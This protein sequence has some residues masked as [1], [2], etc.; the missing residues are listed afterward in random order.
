LF[1]EV[2]PCLVLTHGRDDINRTSLLS[3]IDCD[4]RLDIDVVHNPSTAEDGSFIDFARKCVAAGTIRSFTLFEENI[5]N[6][7]FLL[8]LL[9]NKNRYDADFVIVSDG[10][11]LAPKTLVD[12]Q[13]AI[14]EHHT[15]VLACGLRLDATVWDDSLVIKDDF[16]RRFNTSRYDEGDYLN[17]AT[18]MWMTM[19]RGPEL[20]SIL[21]AIHDNGLRLTDANLKQ[22]GAALFQKQ[23]VATKSSVGRELN[24]ERPDYHGTKAI[25][26]QHFAHHSPEPAGSKYATW[27]H[28]CVAPAVEWDRDGERPVNFAP[29][30]EARPRFR[31]TIENDPVVSKLKSGQLHHSR[32]YLANHLLAATNPGLAFIISDGHCSTGLPHLGPERSALYIST[33]PEPGG[34]LAALEEVDLGPVLLTLEAGHCRSILST[35]ARFLGKGAL[36]HGILFGADDVRHNSSLGN[37]PQASLL[38]PALRGSASELAGKRGTGDGAI[39]EFVQ[40]LWTDEA[41]QD[42]LP[43]GASPPF[44]SKSVKNPNLSYFRVTL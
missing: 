26:T 29:L 14:F 34:L 9:G 4:P 39:G 35:T 22:L 43:Q 21:E 44:F 3:I 16:V 40:Q 41:L 42:W 25:S 28:N 6:N 23:W 30:P 12:E 38:P 33:S 32:G 19:F 1:K 15:E 11:I 5:S 31:G 13:L 8:F 37:P 18:G 27:N 20:V 36:L 17:T 10:D 7:A 24:R 2:I